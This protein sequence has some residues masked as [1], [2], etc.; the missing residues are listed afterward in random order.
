MA[1]YKYCK[2]DESRVEG[3]WE[4]GLPPASRA[5]KGDKHALLSMC[6]DY[7]PEKAIEEGI[8]SILDYQ[9][10]KCSYSLFSLTVDKPV[11]LIELKNE[12]R[13]GPSGSG[14]SRSARTDYPGIFVKEPNE[15]WTGYNGELEVLIEDVDPY[16]RKLTG[17]LKIWSD[18][19]AFKA[20]IH[21]GYLHIRP[22]RIV[23]TSQYSPEEIWQ[24]PK[25]IDAIRRR[26][27]VIHY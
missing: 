23:V 12:W 1:A 18:H 16:K 27:K 9:K 10:L 19:Y 26:F 5:V 8:V 3:P 14:K 15:W 17:D 13:W 4:H 22:E 7:G 11:D 24:D 2:K 25:T 20:R 21:G 6:K